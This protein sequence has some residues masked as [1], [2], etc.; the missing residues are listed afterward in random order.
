MKIVGATDLGGLGAYSESKS[1]FSILYSFRD[2]RVH[3]YDF[4]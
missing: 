1:Q 3:I 2:I 4:F